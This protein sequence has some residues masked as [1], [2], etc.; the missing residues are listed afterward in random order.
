MSTIRLKRC[1]T[2]GLAVLLLAGAGISAM[3]APSGTQATAGTS[4]ATTPASRA[5]FNRD[6]QIMRAQM[7]QLHSTRDPAARAKLLDAHMRTMQKTLRMMMGQGGM[8]GPGGMGPG[9]MQGGGMG[10]AAG[11]MGNGQMMQMMMGQMM[12]HQQAMQGMGCT[13]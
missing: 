9:M 5:A 10:S 11:M 6:M 1:V 4:A 13:R 3:A 7:M 2:T 8:G 12:Q